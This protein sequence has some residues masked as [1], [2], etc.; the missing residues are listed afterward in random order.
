MAVVMCPSAVAE[1]QY[2]PRRLAGLPPPSLVRATLHRNG[3]SRLTRDP[4]V[5]V[6]L[7]S[8]SRIVALNG[9]RVWCR[10]YPGLGGLFRKD[11]GPSKELGRALCDDVKA[12]FRCDGFFTTDELPRYGIGRAA[13]RD[14][15]AATGASA[16]DCVMVYAYPKELALAVDEYVHGRLV[17][18]A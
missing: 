1:R 7:D 10:R 16:A 18:M 9:A 5:A 3:A 2:V 11:R 13:R 17:A 8:D 4:L 12:G 14:I 6:G 15:L